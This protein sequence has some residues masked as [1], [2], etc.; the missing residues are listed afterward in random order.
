MRVDSLSSFWGSEVRAW[1]SRSSAQVPQ[2]R[3]HLQS[4]LGPECRP[5]RGCSDKLVGTIHLPA[6]AG[7][8][9]VLLNSV[10]VSLATIIA[11][12]ITLTVLSLFSILWHLGPYSPAETP[13]PNS[14]APGLLIPEDNDNFLRGT[15]SACKPASPQS[16]APNFSF[17]HLSCSQG[18]GPAH[19]TVPRPPELLKPASPQLRALPA[20]PCLPTETPV[21]AL[22][23]TSPHGCSCLW[24]TLMAPGGPC[25]VAWH[26][27]PSP[28]GKWK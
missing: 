9:C 26:G 12:T 28:P 14:P 2:S 15:T 23:H 11:G 27:V 17:L 21:M 7:L 10:F 6:A 24:T 13:P 1:L 22:I 25:G 3:R 8:L 4:T 5:I 19:V 20:L 18:Q 16:T